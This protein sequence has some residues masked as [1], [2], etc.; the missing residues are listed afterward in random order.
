MSMPTIAISVRDMNGGG[1]EIALQ[2]LDE[3]ETNCS[4]IILITMNS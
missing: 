2:S 1:T 3:I 4:A